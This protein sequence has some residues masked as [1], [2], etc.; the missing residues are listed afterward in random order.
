[1][2]TSSQGYDEDLFKIVGFRTEIWR[3]KDDAWEDVIYELM[4]VTDGEWLEADENEITL[5]A[6]EG[7]AEAFIKKYGF[8][9][10]AKKGMKTKKLPSPMGQKPN[11]IDQLL[12]H[13]N[14]YK[15]LYELFNVRPVIEASPWGTDGGIL[16]KG[17]GIPVAVFGPGTTE[18]AHDAD[19]SI[20][21]E[22]LF[23]SAEILAGF[24]VEWCNQPV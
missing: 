16:S 9:F 7:Q 4:R 5:V 10:P 6:D 13:Y 18:L 22:H 12:D 8:V 20:E 14:D 17:A 23:K 21:L 11:W 2:I 24:I 1:M 19:E 15:L 3:Y